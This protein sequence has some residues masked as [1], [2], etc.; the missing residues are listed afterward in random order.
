MKIEKINDNQIKCTLTSEDLAAR[1][2]KLS[3]LAYGTDKA[4]DLFQDMMEQAHDEFGFE[5]DN[6]PLMIEA[7]PLSAD[8]IVLVITKVDNPEELDTRFAKFAPSNEDT[9]TAEPPQL[10]GADDIIDLI[11]KLREAKEKALAA[12]KNRTKES[13]SKEKETR[14]EPSEDKQDVPVNLVRLF[15]FQELN[16]VI[17]ASH[18]LN[19]Y[20][21]GKNTLYRNSKKDCYQLVL[22]QSGHSP[23]DF[24]RICNILS[25]YGNGTSLSAAGEAYFQ[26]HMETFVPDEALQKLAQL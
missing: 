26:E 9:D 17:H 21:T 22:H 4:R 3:E 23:E 6:A 12:V 24:N 1:E 16:D 13:V 8:T 11:Q 25:E 19:H 15:Q 14:K 2:I 10:S 20:Y 5:A 7:I 18:G